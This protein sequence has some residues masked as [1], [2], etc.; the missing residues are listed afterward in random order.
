MGTDL[1]T[2]NNI[3]N[4]DDSPSI[5]IKTPQLIYYSGNLIQGMITMIIKKQFLIKKLNVKLHQN[6]GWIMFNSISNNTETDI[7]EFNIDLNQIN[8]NIVYGQISLS[9]NS[10]Y[11]P[12]EIQIPLNILPTFYY[13]NDG[14]KAYIT[15]SI[16]ICII[17]SNEKE[18]SFEYY[19]VIKMSENIEVDPPFP[20]SNKMD[21]KKL[22]FFNAG[23]NILNVQIDQGIFLYNKPIYFQITI[24]NKNC[25]A[26][27]ESVHYIL[28]R[29]IYLY[30]KKKLKRATISD[31]IIENDI[32]CKI[33]EKELRNLY[34]TININD[35]LI[36]EYNKKY[37]MILGKT[38]YKS[39]I[40]QCNFLIPTITTNELIKCEYIISFSLRYEGIY[41]NDNINRI[42]IPLI[43]SNFSGNNFPINNSNINKNNNNINKSAIYNNNNNI[44]LNEQISNINNSVNINLNNNIFDNKNNQQENINNID[45]NSNIYPD[46][47]YDSI[48]QDAPP[49]QF[50]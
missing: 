7:N 20:F 21:V 48:D 24:D 25:L 27:V 1:F 9:P 4:L 35:F 46:N 13:D 42:N 14:K 22:Q 8:S 5:E 36:N 30:D 16:K 39:L 45:I 23:S 43:I 34:L 31:L 15:Y 50:K 17:D 49:A 44:K 40:T 19:I 37:F 26:T 28:K 10:Y 12:F 41:N 11:F 29:Y 18:Y 32:V 3:K 33:E 2:N 38:N 6:I 47:I